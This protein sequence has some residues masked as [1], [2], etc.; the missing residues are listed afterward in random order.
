MKT[1]RSRPKSIEAL[2]TELRKVLEKWEISDGTE[3]DDFG[4]MF[5][6][7]AGDLLA[8]IEER[9]RED[10]PLPV[11]PRFPDRPTHPDFARLSAT[12]IEQDQRAETFGINAAASVHLPSFAYLAQRRVRMATEGLEL[13]EGMAVAILATYLD[14]F[15][16]GVG[17]AERGGHRP[18]QTGTAGEK[19][20][21]E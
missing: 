9:V 16:L 5:A 2:S 11:D 10:P 1:P 13:G 21:S 17:F 18:S 3:F 12:V 15:Q 19:E 4:H 8:A 20:G 14:A 7:A 6:N